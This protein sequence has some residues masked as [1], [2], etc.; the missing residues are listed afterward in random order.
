[1]R[2]YITVHRGRGPGEATPVVATEDAEVVDATL[3]A[4][5]RRLGVDLRSDRPPNSQR[6]ERRTAEVPRGAPLE[7]G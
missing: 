1:M 7:G 3:R 4:V 6:P 5:A 2:T